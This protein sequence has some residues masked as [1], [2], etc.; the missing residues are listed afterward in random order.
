MY[1]HTQQSGEQRVFALHL[2]QRRHDK[3]VMLITMIG[4]AKPRHKLPQCFEKIRSSRFSP[5]QLVYLV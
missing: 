1:A 4:M 3:L 5:Y 2:D